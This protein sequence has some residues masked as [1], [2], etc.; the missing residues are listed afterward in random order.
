MRRQF[1]DLLYEKMKTN[2]DIWLVTG[3]LGYKMWDNIREDFPDR[4]IN[5]GT[6]EQAMMG[7]A[8][9]LA[10]QGKIPFIYSI[11]P[12]LLWRPAETI[13]LYLNHEN[14]PIKLVGGGRDK[15]YKDDGFSHDARDITWLLNCW[16][17]IKQ[18]WPREDKC[19]TSEWLDEII[20]N[21]FPSFISLRR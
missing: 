1:A 5:A 7:V 2:K 21:N 12:F 8:V 13:R 6:S 10:M 3:D 20:N 14:C 16:P 15:D 17:N 4:F 9:G 11:T 19:V 18:F